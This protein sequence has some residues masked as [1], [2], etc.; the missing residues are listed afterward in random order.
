MKLNLDHA[1]LDNICKQLQDIVDS[2]LITHSPHHFELKNDSSEVTKLDLLLSDKIKEVLDFIPG[3]FYSEEEYGELHFPSKIVDPL[4]GTKEFIKGSD[5]WSVSVLIAH[6]FDINDSLSEAFIFQ[7]STGFKK[8]HFSEISN[9]E[10]PLKILVSR[11]EWGAKQHPDTVLPFVIEPCGSIAL[12]LAK[13]LNGEAKAV[14]SLRPKHIWDIAAGTVLLHRH[15]FH[16]YSEGKRVFH[17][18]KKLFKPPLIWVKPED[19]IT[20]PL[21]YQQHLGTNP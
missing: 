10:S 5:E 12:K 6:S 17:L 20:L 2:F 18:N 4:D 8:D 14:C 7:P 15:G 9:K 13:L 19:E 1:K 21:F 3:T 16:F 11:S